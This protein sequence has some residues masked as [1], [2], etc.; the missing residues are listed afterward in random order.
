MG[1]F[2]ETLQT[3]RRLSSTTGVIS[4]TLSEAL[5][6]VE[7][8]DARQV[9]GLEIELAELVLPHAPPGAPAQLELGRA[10]IEGRGS[11]SELREARQD[12]WA[13]AGSLACGCSTADSA[14]AHAILACLEP[15]ERAHDAKS[16]VE[17]V[18]RVVRCGVAEA[19]ILAVLAGALRAASSR[20]DAEG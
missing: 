19:R 13:Y 7:T 4:R 20:R 9:H 18:T 16:L 2:L 11:V 17:Q 15:D 8:L 3:V 12:C 14:S 5:E 6:S 1:F 10:L